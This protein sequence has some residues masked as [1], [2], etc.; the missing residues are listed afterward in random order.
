[1][2]NAVSDFLMIL[3]IGDLK[4]VEKSFGVGNVGNVIFAGV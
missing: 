4:R 1:M 2:I 3:F